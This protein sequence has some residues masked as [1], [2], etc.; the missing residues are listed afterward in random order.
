MN[1]YQIGCTHAGVH[2]FS[3]APHITGV[4]RWWR[5]GGLGA[6]ISTPSIFLSGPN[7]S[8]NKSQRLSPNALWQASAG[9]VISVSLWCQSPTSGMTPFQRRAAFPR[10]FSPSTFHIV[11]SYGDMGTSS[12]IYTHSSS[13]SLLRSGKLRWCI[14]LLD[15]ISAKKKT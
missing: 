5:L 7:T 12:L 9:H 14:I 15:T 8:W 3:R 6:T 11:L 13:S 1:L 10:E 2:E 4:M